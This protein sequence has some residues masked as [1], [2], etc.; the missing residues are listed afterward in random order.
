M[1]EDD[2]NEAYKIM[3]GL[4]PSLSTVNEEQVKMFSFIASDFVSKSRFKGD[5]YYRALALY[6]LHL[7]FLDGALKGEDEDIESYS[8]RVASFSLTGEFSQTFA[9]VN[10]NGADD[11]RSTPWGRMFRAL[12]IKSGGGFALM[13]APRRCGL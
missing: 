2:F 9:S 10:D 5:R 11:I 7:M 8:R 12:L 4:V 6:S 13:T 3:I 1:N